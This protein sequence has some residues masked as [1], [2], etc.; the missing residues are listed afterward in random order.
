MLEGFTS[1]VVAKVALRCEE[2]LVH[3]CSKRRQG[4]LEGTNG[5]IISPLRLFRGL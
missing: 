4:F 3:R 1:M 2:S 5:L